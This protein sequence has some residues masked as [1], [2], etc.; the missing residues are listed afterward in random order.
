MIFSQSWH[1]RWQLL[2][3]HHNLVLELVRRWQ[4]LAVLPDRIG[5]QHGTEVVLHMLGH[6]IL[7]VDCI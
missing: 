6:F 2:C 1:T 3:L 5:V 7:K 4:D